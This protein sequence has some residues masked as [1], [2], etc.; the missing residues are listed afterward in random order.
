MMVVISPSG[1]VRSRASQR[2]AVQVESARWWIE[3]EQKFVGKTRLFEAGRF[4]KNAP[5]YAATLAMSQEPSLLDMI[6]DE[7]TEC[8]RTD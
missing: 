4:R 2:A 1:T 7:I 3:K 8:R 6:D 5:S